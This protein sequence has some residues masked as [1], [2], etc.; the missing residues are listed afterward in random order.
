MNFQTSLLFITA[1]VNSILSLFVLFGKRNKTNIVYSLFVLFASMWAVGLAF[2]ILEPD[3]SKAI[4]FADFYY[5]SAV[6]IPVFFLYFSLVFLRKEQELKSREEVFVVAPLAITILFFLLDKNVL[7]KEVFLTSWGKDVVFNH[8]NY[9]IYTVYFLIFVAFAYYNLIKTSRVIKTEEEKN[10][11]DFV[12][13]G[14][15]IGFIFGMIFD[16]FLP[17]AGNYRYIFIGPLFSFSMVASIAYS[18]TRYHLFNIKVIATEVLIFLMWIFILIRI[19]VSGTFEDQIA[20]GGLLIISVIAGIF[21]IKSVMKEVEQ[22]EKIETLAK[23]LEGANANLAQVNNDLAGANER[24]K[25][26]DQ[27]K[28][29]F[30]SLA[31]HQIR[32]PLTAIKGYASLLLEGDYGTLT[33][34][35]TGAVNTIFQSCQNLVVIVNEFLDISR[36][37]Q[38]RMKY[39]VSEFDV[40][41]VCEDTL[42]ELMP[43]IEHAGLSATFSA[44]DKN[45]NWSG[46]VG[47]VKQIVGNIIDNAIKYTPTGGSIS[48]NLTQKSNKILVAV[49]DTGIGIDKQDI[50][51]LFSKFSRTKD[52]NKQ[53]VIGT[54]LGLYVAKQMI[55]AQGGKV[56]VESKGK[57]LGSSFY[58]ELPIKKQ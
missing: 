40:K 26:L 53:N 12:I 49:T 20:N 1:S 25:E 31:T 56:W 30:L 6:G 27:L 58:I 52:A 24:L 15:A 17:L 46:D 55:E 45:F 51:K 23:D 13:W 16:L 19:F 48:L 29:E 38:G 14:T 18:I 32:A 43:N 57:G 21:L 42:N 22:R 39:E 36:I 47:K 10:Q 41:K 2:F 8:L 28:S 54:G 35:V 9:F 4:Y 3:L 50:P 44:E 11:L 7:I 33:P 37:E 5:I 34:E